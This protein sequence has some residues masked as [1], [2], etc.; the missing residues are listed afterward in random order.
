MLSIWPSRAAILIQFATLI[1][2]HAAWQGPPFPLIPER[3]RELIFSSSARSAVK[4]TGELHKAYYGTI[5]PIP[6][7][8]SSI[9]TFER[10]EI[11]RAQSG[12]V[13]IELLLAFSQLVGGV[14]WSAPKLKEITWSSEMRLRSVLLTQP[15]RNG[16]GQGIHVFVQDDRWRG[17]ED[18]VSESEASRDCFV[19]VVVHRVG[20]IV[21][22][23]TRIQSSQRSIQRNENQLVYTG[24]RRESFDSS[25]N[26]G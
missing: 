2:L 11:Y 13:V 12:Q 22:F 1:F 10:V 9:S 7:S 6:V 20:G 16:R 21:I 3:T 8:F 5:V 14:I 18:C 17:L 4:S 23:S 25:Y 15:R 24:R 26:H 19:Q